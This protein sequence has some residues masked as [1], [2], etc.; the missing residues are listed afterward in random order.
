MCLKYAQYCP[1][2]T[3]QGLYCRFIQTQLIMSDTESLFEDLLSLQRQKAV[4][5]V[6]AWQPQRVGEI[7]IRIARDGT[8]YHAGGAIRRLGLVRLFASVMRRDS[9]GFCLVT[10]AEKL[11]IEVEDAP[12]MAIDMEVRGSDK[13]AEV[14]FTTNVEDYVLIDRQ[15]PMRVDEVNEEPRPYIHVRDGLDAL[16]TRAVYYRLVEAAITEGRELVIYSCG[17]RFSLGRY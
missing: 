10:P 2:D 5:P 15:H 12:F 16:M 14:L 17:E 8:W 1:R 3:A 9:D 7:D 6:S 4:P 11:F 13:S